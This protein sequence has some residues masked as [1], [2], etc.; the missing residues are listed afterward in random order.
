MKIIT[1]IAA[2]WLSMSAFIIVMLN[3]HPKSQEEQDYED[4]EQTEYVTK[5]QKEHNL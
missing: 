2:A 4:Q 3:A 1:T 5:W